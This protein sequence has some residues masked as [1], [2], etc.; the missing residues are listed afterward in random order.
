MASKTKKKQLRELAKEMK[1]LN[2]CVKQ[3]QTIQGP[4]E[5]YK[6]DSGPPRGAIF[7]ANYREFS[8]KIEYE[9]RKGS[10]IDVQNLTNLFRQMGYDHIVEGIQDC[11]KT[12]TISAMRSLVNTKFT[13]Q[14]IA[15]FLL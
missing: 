11:T 6:N 7:I 9:K 5:A 1:S 10:E 15:W 4:P 13:R 8:D 3:V 14:L 12:E 2:I